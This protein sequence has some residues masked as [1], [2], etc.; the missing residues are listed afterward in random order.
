MVLR[1]PSIMINHDTLDGT[2]ATEYFPEAGKASTFPDCPTVSGSTSVFRPQSM[3]TWFL[4]AKEKLKA[5]ATLQDNWD[6]YGALRTN[7]LSLHHAHEF[8]VFIGRNN[9][10]SEPLIAVN[11]NGYVCFEWELEY[12][13]IELQVLPTGMVCYYLNNHEMDQDG[14]DYS[15]Y[16]NVLQY[17]ANYSTKQR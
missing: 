10:I 14:E 13:A 11:S 12:F 8:L 6:S 4:P 3:S 15:P 5:A 1:P 17:I 9:V 2:E 7:S 16:K